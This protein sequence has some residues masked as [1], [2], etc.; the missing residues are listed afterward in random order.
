M[1]ASGYMGNI[2]SYIVMNTI[3]QC[4]IA[5]VGIVEICKQFLGCHVYI[6]TH[7]FVIYAGHKDL[8]EYQPLERN[9]TNRYVCTLCNIEIVKSSPYTLEVMVSRHMRDLSDLSHRLNYFVS[10]LCEL[11]TGYISK[12]Y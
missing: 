12:K 3:A 7:P 2:L 9:H 8:I 1:C 5:T 10:H 11:K 6:Q 4:F